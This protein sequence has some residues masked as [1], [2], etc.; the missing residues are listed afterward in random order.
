MTARRIIVLMGGG[1]IFTLC[2]FPPWSVQIAL[3]S[4]TTAWRAGPYAPVGDPPQWHRY[5]SSEG[6]PITGYCRSRIDVQRLAVQIL[7]VLAGSAVAYS[8]IPNQLWG[9]HRKTEARN[10]G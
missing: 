5:L 8:L 6:K 10:P 9:K 2:I 3:P 7:A 1:A 4:G